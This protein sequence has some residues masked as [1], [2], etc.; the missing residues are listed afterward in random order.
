MKKFKLPALPYAYDA[1]EPHISER[2]L[3]IHHDKHHKGYVDNANKILNRMSG[4]KSLL[5]SFS[6]NAAG[7]LLHSLFWTNMSP[8]GGGKPKGKLLK[9]ISDDFGSYE[10]FKQEF[11]NAA[12]SVEGSGWAALTYSQDADGVVLIQIE[13]HNVN[14]VPSYELLLVIDVWEHAYYLDY[15]NN[16]GAFVEAFWEVVNWD[17]VSKRFNSVK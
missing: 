11:S 2:T 6:Y 14:I 9:A 16:R 15:Q 12:K 7:Q 4:D 5:K 13:K 8:N 3:R 1:L 10:A 17:E